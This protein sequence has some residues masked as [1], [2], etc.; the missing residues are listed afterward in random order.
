[1]SVVADPTPSR[2]SAR[3][4]FSK[5]SSNN[6]WIYSGDTIA[7]TPQTVKWTEV[8]TGQ[9]ECGSCHGL[10]PEGHKVFPRQNLKCGYCHPTASTVEDFVIVDPSLHANGQADVY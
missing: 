4:A 8:G 5:A 6:Q 10:P 1:M 7:G 9:A 2:T 3:L